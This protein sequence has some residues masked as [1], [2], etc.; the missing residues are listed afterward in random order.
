M[1]KNSW[2][3]AART[4]LA[5]AFALALALPAMAAGF[6]ATPDHSV[7]GWVLDGAKKNADGTVSVTI[8]EVP[9]FA[10]KTYTTA[11]SLADPAHTNAIT[12]V[13]RADSLAN[14]GKPS[15]TG[16]GSDQGV[17]AKDALAEI[18]FNA[19]GQCVDMEVVEFGDPSYMDSASYG[20]ELT[21]KGGGAGEMVST[22]WVLA[23]DADRR[24]ITIGD[25]NHVTNVF[26]EVYTLADDCKIFLVDNSTTDGKKPIAGTLGGTYPVPGSWNL[27]KKA[28]FSDIKLCE[29]QNGEIYYAPERWTAVCVFDKNYKSSWK[30]GSAKVRELYLFANPLK[31]T[32]RDMATPDGM[33][34]DGTSPYPAANKTQEKTWFSFNGSAEPIEFMKDRLYDVGDSYTEIWLFK[35]DDGTVTLLDQGN[36]TA[37]YQYWLN[38]AKIGIDPRSVDNIALTHGHGDHYQALYENVLMINR[39]GG[40]ARVFIN[41]YAQGSAI[42][43]SPYAVRAT[44]TDKPVLYSATE[45]IAWDKWSASM[46]PGISFYVWRSLGHSDDTASFIFK[47][48]AKANDEYFKKGDV[49]SWVYYGGYGAKTSLSS[50]YQNLAI[51]AGLQYQQAVIAPWAKAQ[52]DYVYS[53]AQHSNQYPVHEILKATKIAGVPYMRG[54]SEGIESVAN[55]CEKRVSVHI[56]EWMEQAYRNKT[57]ALGNILE[58][59][60]AGFRCDSSSATNIDTIQAHGPYKR[61]DGEYTIDVQAVSVIH[62]F[63]AF[64]N[65][66]PLFA[67]QKSLYGFSLDQGF[68]IDKDS[69]TH[70]PDGWYVQVVTT[71]RDGY[72]G[73]VN[74]DTN[75]FKGNYV[76]GAKNEPLTKP[77]ASGPVDVSINPK[78]WTET[79]R[80]ER[81]ASREQA[82]AFAKALTNGK[83]TTPFNGYGVNGPMFNYID[84]ADHALSDHD[85]KGSAL[86]TAAYRVRL[87]RAS[88]I[89][90]GNSFETTFIKAY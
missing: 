46:G 35:A 5:F 48:V 75:W 38:I 7:Y 89:L 39:A 23:K 50:G 82:E 21:A 67:N 40:K 53:L 74:Y 25:G 72:D 62:G 1:K 36:R 16:P 19:A 14:D 18:I 88:E 59:S 90:L 22:G 84:K 3:R 87:N 10:A 42:E 80:T 78:A 31:L 51:V 12:K 9:A 6:D 29:R 41:P 15:T 60:A 47:T 30:E 17:L 34:Y 81:F 56:Y 58:K 49:V 64:L 32:K 71:V 85:G 68:V 13:T 83:Y 69:Y 37:S 79:L 27:V 61:S 77:W 70:D 24:T 2:S 11:I 73:G 66:S 54:Y 28:D 76:I 33:Q 57:D 52:S 55:F 65:K 43:N 86:P 45:L 20:G 44:L 4:A 63:D 26:E 8:M